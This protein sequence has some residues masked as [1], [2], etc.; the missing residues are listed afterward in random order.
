M[1][2]TN[3]FKLTQSSVKER[4]TPPEPGETNGNGKPV[5]QKLYWDS[6]LKGFGFLLG[7]TAKTLRIGAAAS[8]GARPTTAWT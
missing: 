7:K 8:P 4:C 1:A 3:R 6:E 5:T 2:S